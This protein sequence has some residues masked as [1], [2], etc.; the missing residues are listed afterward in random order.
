MWNVAF[1][2]LVTSRSIE[3]VDALDKLEQAEG[4]QSIEIEVVD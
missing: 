3:G 4:E 2:A 1:R